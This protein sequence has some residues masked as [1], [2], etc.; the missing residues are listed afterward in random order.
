VTIDEGVEE[1]AGAVEEGY[2]QSIAALSVE[3]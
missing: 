2:V 3:P 1:P